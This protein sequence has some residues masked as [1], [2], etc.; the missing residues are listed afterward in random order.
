MNNS[1]NYR[2]GEKQITSTAGE[3][4]NEH[5]YIVRV[6]ENLDSTQRIVIRSIDKVWDLDAPHQ[7]KRQYPGSQ[8]KQQ[9]NHQLESKF[10]AGTE[11]PRYHSGLQYVEENLTDWYAT[12]EPSPN[13]RMSAQKRKASKADGDEVEILPT[14]TIELSHYEDLKQQIVDRGRVIDLL[15]H[16][17]QELKPDI[18][19]E[20]PHREDS[21]GYTLSYKEKREKEERELA[22]VHQERAIEKIMG[23]L[24]EML[25][26]SGNKKQRGE[27][28]GITSDMMWQVKESTHEK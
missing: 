21:N 9:N 7:A 5:T 26:K 1:R 16:K 3:P 10:E 2:R 15:V 24:D 11:D 8:R 14:K 25:Q 20:L 4:T 18:D 12:S 17:L 13:R 28:D 27:E 19:L 6:A 23:C 22:K